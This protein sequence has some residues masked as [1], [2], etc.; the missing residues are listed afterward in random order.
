MRLGHPYLYIN[1]FGQLLNT[2]DESDIGFFIE[3]NLKYPNEF[4]EKTKN[5]PFRP[6]K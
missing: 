3:V 1:K 6:E 2:P 5:F 4:K